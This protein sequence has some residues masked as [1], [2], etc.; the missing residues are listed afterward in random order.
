MILKIKEEDAPLRND[1][2][3]CLLKCENCFYN[4]DFNFVK[5]HGW[6]NL[7]YCCLLLKF[8]DFL[9]FSKGLSDKKFKELLLDDVYFKPACFKEKGKNLKL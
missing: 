9:K 1:V 5:R 2:M 4:L 6:N 7:N 8:S 3:A